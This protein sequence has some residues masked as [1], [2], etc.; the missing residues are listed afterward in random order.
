MNYQT[1]QECEDHLHQR[2]VFHNAYD[3]TKI[4]SLGAYNTIFSYDR[5]YKALKELPYT[6][7]EWLYFAEYW[8]GLG[9]LGPTFKLIAA[10]TKRKINENE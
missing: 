2:L 4:A 6:K 3:D 10:V 7:E 1:I 8:E 5:F 9:Y